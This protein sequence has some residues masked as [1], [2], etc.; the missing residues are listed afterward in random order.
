VRGR[1]RQAVGR[2][3]VRLIEAIR[4][5]D[6]DKVTEAVMALSQ[7]SRWL[8]PLAM[9]VG[10]FAMLFQGLKLLV[11]EWR[12]TLIQILPAMWIWLAM[13][14]LKVHA[15]HDRSFHVLRGPVLIPLVLA[16]AVITA[17]SFYLNAVFAFAID[18]PG[19]PDIPSGF[20]RAR[21]HL[22]TILAWG[23]VVGLALGFST[24]VITR[25]GK[26]WFALALSIVVGVMMVAYVA[27]PARLTGVKSERSARD[28]LAATAIGGAIGAMV[29][30]P[31]YALGRVAVLLLGS[32]RFRILAVAMLVVAVILQTG[33]TTSVKAV[34]MS[35]KLAVGRSITPDADPAAGSP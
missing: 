25:W 11:T 18:R 31:P 4:D 22:W 29:C 32:H 8:A 2:L 20:A 23:M 17:A 3:V 30:S 12:L 24:L 27:V 7:R 15:L 16:V 34:K 13:L 1:R 28:K 14:D 9:V 10:A 19:T 33:A 26:L 21:I 35:A 5:E 6:E